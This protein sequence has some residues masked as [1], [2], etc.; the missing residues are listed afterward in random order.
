MLL[1]S[2]FLLM[3]KL[4]YYILILLALTL[5]ACESNE[6]VK[7]IK[8]ETGLL[9][10]DDRLVS[11]NLRLIKGK[12]IAV[13]VNK[14]SVLSDGTPLLD[15][16]LR[17]D[18]VE[19]SAVFT[20]EHGY[21]INTSAGRMVYDSSFSAIP[22]YSLYGRN[23][24]PTPEMLNS[25]D[26]ILFDLQDVGTRFYTYISTL[27]Y[28]MQAA[29]ENNIPVIVLDRPDPIS[30]NHV[31]GPV[32]DPRFQSFIGIAPIPVIYG[33]TAGELAQL[34]AGE[35]MLPVIPELKVI[36][37]KN[38]RRDSFFNDYNL[39]WINPSPNIPDFETALIYPSTALL[40]GTNVSEGRGTDKPFR[41]IGAPF[42]NSSDLVNELNLFQNEGVSIKPVNFIPAALPGK[43]EN[44]KYK[45]ITCNG[46]LINIT[47]PLEFKP[48][49]FSIQLLYVLHKLY[50]EKF[51]FEPAVF[52]KLVGETSTRKMLYINITPAEI[53]NSWEPGLE[54]FLKIRTKYLLY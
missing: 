8:A 30:G 51:K 33:M 6:Q 19:I 10:G 24:K 7:V 28:V 25:I 11:S 34:F 42:I 48:M 41:Q 1:D 44:P 53:I 31:A 2:L 27:F 18:S 37:L 5:Q 43:A 17:I 22:F 4:K 20:P 32:L 40:E 45:N 38:W 54:N 12:R 46:I 50:P 29:G 9:L 39:E 49:V 13:V 36:R 14:A 16:L 21:N 47:N 52:D 3:D 35:S 23:K 26:V 15:T